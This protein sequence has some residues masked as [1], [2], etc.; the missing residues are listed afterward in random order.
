MVSQ[1]DIIK[2]DF[3]PQ[4]GFEQAGYRPAV[5]IS[6]DYAIS[7]H[8]NVVYVCPISNTTK[9]YPTHIPLD[10]RTKTTGVILCEHGKAFDLNTR[11]FVFVEKCPSD[12]LNKVINRVKALID[13]P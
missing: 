4:V 13:I 1:G 9:P 8:R 7:R 11:T 6:N 3:D 5:V 12:I 10:N 2:I